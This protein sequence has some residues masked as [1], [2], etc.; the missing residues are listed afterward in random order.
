MTIRERSSIRR[1]VPAGK[2]INE[3]QPRDSKGE[4]E[5]GAVYELAYGTTVPGEMFGS[6]AI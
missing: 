5:L 4:Q 1:S 3:W 2:L 6:V